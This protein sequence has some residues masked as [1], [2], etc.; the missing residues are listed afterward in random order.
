MIISG[1]IPVCPLTKY[2]TTGIME[3]K[4]TQQKVQNL[5]M[6]AA[7]YQSQHHDCRWGQSVFNALELLY[8]AT[9]DEV[10][11]T[12]FDCFYKDENVNKLLVHI[13]K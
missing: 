5:L 13:T 9:A 2:N 6:A 11:G 4:I 3:N 1:S 8:K 12:E 10:R 7:T